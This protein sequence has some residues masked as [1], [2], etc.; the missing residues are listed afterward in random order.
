MSEA[1]GNEGA[2]ERATPADRAFAKLTDAE[3]ARVRSLAAAPR[4]GP[5]FPFNALQKAYERMLYALAATDSALS[6]MEL[7]FLLAARWSSNTDRWSVQR[8]I[9]IGLKQGEVELVD[10]G[11][12]RLT[13]EGR[14]HLRRFERERLQ[15]S[16]EPRRRPS[17]PGRRS[18]APRR[19]PGGSRGANRRDT[20]R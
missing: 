6:P 17:G 2:P 1:D 7:V 3:R 11:R 12:Y 14:E 18:A 13:D 4:P 15:R 8:R 19:G 9:A 10:G 20:R 16:A 5:G